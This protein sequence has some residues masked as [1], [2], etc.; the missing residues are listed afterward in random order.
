MPTIF[1]SKTS[2]IE[3][4]GNMYKLIYENGENYSNFFDKIKKI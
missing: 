2:K 3:K 1:T 4:T